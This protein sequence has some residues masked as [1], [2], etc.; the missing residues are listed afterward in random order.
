[1]NNRFRLSKLKKIKRFLFSLLMSLVFLKNKRSRV[2]RLSAKFVFEM[3]EKYPDAKFYFSREKL[4]DD[5]ALQLGA[6]D[7]IGLEFGV[8]SGDS[9]KTFLKMP[10][11]KRC[12]AWHGF[13]SF[14]GLPEPWGDLP[15]GAFST[16]GNPPKL[17]DP[18]LNWHI[19]RIEDTYRQI[20]EVFRDNSRALVIF[21]FDL[22]DPSKIA[23][24]EISNHLKPG[25]LVYFDEAYEDDESKLIDAILHSKMINFSIIGFTSMG[26]AFTVV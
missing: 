20:N 6:K 23:W 8:A 13:D 21:D 12:I 24:D 16:G 2:T 7:W 15:A 25:D 4:W 11:A 19:G 26:I 18:R 10:Y 22:Y 5:F 3:S 9:T 14:I 1:L 17:N